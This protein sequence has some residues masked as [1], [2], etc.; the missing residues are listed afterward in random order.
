MDNTV[1]QECHAC[2]EDIHYFE[3]YTKQALIEH[4]LPEDPHKSLLHSIPVVVGHKYYHK[5]CEPAY[6][7]IKTVRLA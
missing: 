4:I 1:I 7:D 3:P 2:G 6:D 5:L